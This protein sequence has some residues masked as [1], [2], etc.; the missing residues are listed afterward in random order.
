M[1]EAWKAVVGFE[2][3]YEVSDL[4]RVRSLRR[5][6][7][8]RNRWGGYETRWTTPRILKFGRTEGGY[9]QAH[10]HVDGDH[11]AQTVHAVVLTAFIGPRPPATEGLHLNH[12]KAD[13]RLVNLK[14]GTHQ[15]NEAAKVAA[16]R[17]LKGERSAQAK[18]LPA[19][20]AAIRRRRGEPQQDLADEF[21]C[22]FS[23]ISA[24]QLRK[25]WRH[26]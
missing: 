22:T 24:I 8:R 1:T 15:E 14:W 13:N 10:F 17:S 18:L 25:S 26:V 5:S 12:N 11:V 23:N 4:G 16:G 19:D 21:G 2:G 7:T 20:I 3:A 9:L 6:Y